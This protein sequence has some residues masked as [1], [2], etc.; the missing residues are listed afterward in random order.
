M[1][2]AEQRCALQRLHAQAAAS[3]RTCA[4]VC[5]LQHQ[6]KGA[7]ANLRGVGARLRGEQRAAKRKGE[8]GEGGERRLTSRPK[9]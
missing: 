7:A 5:A 2:P 9:L 6:R 3:M 4:V 1:L 8:G